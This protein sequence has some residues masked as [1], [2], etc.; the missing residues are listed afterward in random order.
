[1]PFEG[2]N[3]GMIKRLT[4]FVLPK[5]PTVSALVIGTLLCLHPVGAVQRLQDLVFDSYQR[6]SPRIY[7][8]DAQVRVVDIDDA[9]LKQFGQWPWPRD[10]LA[11]LVS[12]LEAHGARAIGFDIVFAEPDRASLDEILRGLPA[13]ASAAIRQALGK[14]PVSNDAIFADA[15]TNTRSVL[16]QTLTTNSADGAAK[17]KASFALAGDNAAQFAVPFA[18]AI[19]PLPGLQAAA[20]GVGAINMALEEDTILRRV[21][22]V[23]SLPNGLTP[24]LDLELLRVSQET[25][26]I[27]IKSSNA[28]GASALGKSTGIVAIKTGAIAI[29]TDPTGA[30]RP[31]FAGE[32]RQRHISAVSI[33]IDEKTAESARDK[34][35]LIGTSAA[36]LNDI[37]A[38]PLSGAVAGVDIHAEVLENI[39]AGALLQRPDFSPA[40]EAVAV[41]V[42]CAIAGAIALTLPPLLGSFLALLLILLAFLTSFLGFQTQNL[43]ID[44]LVPSSF[45]F[46]AFSGTAL[47]KYWQVERQKRWVS[48]AFSRYVAPELVSRLASDPAQLKLGGE[49]RE[50]TIMFC[51]V[52]DFT[53]RAETMSAA[54]VMRFLNRIHTPLSNII[55]KS[56]GTIDKFL[57]DGLMAFWNAPLNVPDHARCAAMA[58][59]EMLELCKALDTTLA[60]EAQAA[61]KAYL[62]LR[63]GIGVNTGS[64][65]VGN[66][67]SDQRFDYSIIGDAVN[68]AARLEVATKTY[69]TPILLSE[70]TA[71]RCAGLDIR[72]VGSLTLKGRTGETAV[73]SLH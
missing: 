73:Y 61:G 26:T 27:L 52:R 45:A 33:L 37:R 22:L 13:D 12:I 35:V 47:L 23:F 29:P 6:L 53:A 21:P 58:A 11:K 25:G 67:G 69:Q 46:L 28:S 9:S 32:Q 43:L 68:I 3:V 54:E 31:H 55:L 70:S 44:A 36:S 71:E 39:L 16:A 60:N 64:V 8:T 40:L 7:D 48:A 62:P 19:S 50:L 38:T 63:I 49:I 18:G 42:M 10:R 5:W 24:S 15:L 72:K 1:M 2:I 20:T 65:F 34:I 30:V 4:D 57:G 59:L 14:N 41:V 51:D 66:M 17:S 56:G